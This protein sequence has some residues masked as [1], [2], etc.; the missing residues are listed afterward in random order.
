MNFAIAY[1]EIGKFLQYRDVSEKH[2]IY[3]Q[4]AIGHLVR[5][6]DSLLVNNRNTEQWYKDASI[7]ILN[8][9]VLGNVKGLL[10]YPVDHN[11][12]DIEIIKRTAGILA[13]KIHG[14][15]ARF[16][17][18]AIPARSVYRLAPEEPRLN[19]ELNIQLN[20]SFS[21]LPVKKIM[22]V[23]TINITSA[24]KTKSKRILARTL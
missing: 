24:L 7:F 15:D 13:N 23:N 22:Q 16:S 1:E 17:L 9:C 5:I 2:N 19:H 20:D 10:P 21:K 11:H 6:G 8:L 12:S 14:V 4:S 18:I 3:I